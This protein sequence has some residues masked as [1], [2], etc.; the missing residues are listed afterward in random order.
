[1]GAFAIRPE[2]RKEVMENLAYNFQQGLN[3]E[4]ERGPQEGMSIPCLNLS[5][6]R[7]A[8]EI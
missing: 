1:M 3:T 7:L 5:I 4:L 6:V 2:C 8:V